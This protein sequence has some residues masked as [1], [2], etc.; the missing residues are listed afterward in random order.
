MHAIA[1]E[2]P[3]LRAEISALIRL[4]A[5]LALVHLGQV[6]LGAVDTAV[7]GRLGELS[8]AATGLGNSVF[9][10]VHV[11]ALGIMLGLDPL[12]SQAVG[13]GDRQGATRLLPQGI[14]VAFLIGLP[15]TLATWG[16]GHALGVFGVQ[17]GTASLTR[18]YLDAR[19]AGFVPYLVFVAGRSYLQ[20]LAITRPMVVGV[21]LANVLNVPLTLLLVYGDAILIRAGLPELGVP[22]LGVAGAG[23]A[24]SA[25]SVLQ[26]AVVL[27]AARGGLRDAAGSWRPRWDVIRKTLRMGMPLGLAMLAE[28]G[29]FSIVSVLMANI[30]STALAAHQVAITLAA[31]TFMVPIAV[32]SAA[33]VRVGYAV[34]RGDVVGARRAGWAS[35]AVG[36]AFM[37]GAALVFLAAAH[38]L[39]R[40]FTNDEVVVEAAAALIA[41]AAVFQLSDG[42]QAVAAGALRGAGDTRWTFYANL[43]GHY[44]VGLPISVALAFV[45]GWGPEGLWWGLCAGLTAVAVGL[46]L[47]FRHVASRA[48][49][50][51]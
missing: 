39:A 46:A 47:R 50:R 17:P 8:L 4:A 24:S 45:L 42:T 51:A 38:P 44:A 12:M 36:V 19:L 14:A 28:V 25:S 18:E 16:S 13:R 2:P 27:A 23:W 10:T 20:S 33:S 35:I 22:R 7:V 6:L 41:V 37:A 34:G 9:F 32:G 30:G 48:I 21:V 15:L 5:P 1:T 40:L 31:L 26:A 49:V 11:A 43:L 29:V 3:S